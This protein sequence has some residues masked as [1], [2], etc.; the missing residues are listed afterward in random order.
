MKQKLI[1]LKKNLNTLYKKEDEVF[2]HYVDGIFE[3]FEDVW[4]ISDAY[5]FFYSEDRI[6]VNLEKQRRNRVAAKQVYIATQFFTPQFLAK[7]VAENSLGRFFPDMHFEYRDGH[8]NFECPSN[9]RIFDPAVG[10]GNM[11]LC[12][13]DLLEKVYRKYEL[14]EREIAQKIL[15]SFFGLD[16][17]KKAVSVAKRL[18]LRRAGLDKFDFSLYSFEELDKSTVELCFSLGLPSLGSFIDFLC[19]NK[20]LGS[21]VRP[22]EG[23]AAEVAVLRKTASSS[24]TIA[25]LEMLT[26][27]YDCILVNPPYLASSDYDAELKKYVFANYYP[28]KQDL[29]AVFISKCFEQLEGGG[30]LG[31]V[32]PYNWMFIK[33]FQ[34]LRR[35]ITQEKGLLNLAQL[36]TGGYSKAV[37]YLSA[38]TAAH[39]KPEKGIYI[40]LT[41]FDGN[42]QQSRLKEAINN[43]VNYRYERCYDTFKKTPQSA[44]IYW[45]TPQAIGCFSQTKLSDYLEIRQGMATGDNKAFLK[46]IYEVNPGNIAFNARSI[47]HFDTLDKKY[48]LYN[49]GGL[50][51]KWFGNINYVIRFDAEARKTLIKQGN[52]MPSKDFYF[53]ECITWTLV[54]SKGHFGARYSNNAVFDVG[55]SCGFVKMDSPA[56]IYVILGFLCSKVATFFLNA[57]NPTLNVQVGD[58]KNLPFVLPSKKQRAEISALVKENIVISR[59]DWYNN[60][61]IDDF[62]RMKYNEER[63]N[64][65]FIELFGLGEEL[66][67][68]VDLKL[69]T[70]R[71]H[72]EK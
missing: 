33:S 69:I 19:K 40:R 65:I 2:E 18:L 41:D 56:D 58:L 55:G 1:A 21:I 25:I 61:E 62:E 72:N 43:P 30:A 68:K 53:K 3:M 35:L 4:E 45:L 52:N 22:Y 59:R 44:V 54:S 29:F 10:T 15:S 16:I 27:K 71:R 20:H 49:K 31:V 14:S 66:D 67:K 17:D 70:L 26:M 64:T 28:Y 50:Y 46:K 23:L 11:F 51:R 47:E 60:G 5:S 7:Y 38:F 63:L 8:G 36:S 32:C 48:A 34:N 42:S 9:L 37:V 57:L 39:K 12:A 24:A 13:Y 6:A